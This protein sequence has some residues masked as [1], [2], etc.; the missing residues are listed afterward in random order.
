[1]LKIMIELNYVH[2]ITRNKLQPCHIVISLI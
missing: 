2:N 1:M